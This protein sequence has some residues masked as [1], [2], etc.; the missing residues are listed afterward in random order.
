MATNALLGIFQADGEIGISKMVHGNMK[1]NGDNREAV[2]RNRRIFVEKDFRAELALGMIGVEHG[3]N[4]VVAR[5]DDGIESYEGADAIVTPDAGFVVGTTFA[6]CP[7][8]YFFHCEER[9][10]G[11]IHCSYKTVLKME[12]ISNALRASARL[13]AGPKGLLVV[14]G[15]GICRYCYEI[16]E[17]VLSVYR[18]YGKYVFR[19]RD[20][21][22][23]FVDLKSI[24][25][26]KM[27]EYGVLAKNIFK[28]DQCTCCHNDK[29][30]HPP[31]FSARRMDQQPP[32]VEAGFAGIMKRW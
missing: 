22:K 32:H 6:D 5:R 18:G 2:L 4:V 7:P 11:V 20:D 16:G 19:D 21:G 26:Q 23:I 29:T 30:G 12:I 13:G 25:A 8:A 9:V 14:I 1:I 24:I 31:F 17:D 3:P 15:P 10:L 28:M 27:I